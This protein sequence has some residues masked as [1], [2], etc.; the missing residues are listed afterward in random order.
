M[1][2][3]VLGACLG[4]DEDSLVERDGFELLADGGDLVLDH[5]PADCVA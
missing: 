3:G 4:D 5:H 2:S 1:G